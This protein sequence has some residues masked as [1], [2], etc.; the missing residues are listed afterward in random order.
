VADRK[1]FYDDPSLAQVD[2]EVIDAGETDGKPWVRLAETIFY[3][4]GGGQPADRGTIAGIAVLDVRARGT[5]VL[6]FVERPVPRGPAT[7]ILDAARRFDFRQQHTA[8]HALTALLA[9]RHDRPTTAF[10]LGDAYAAIEVAG[11][12]PSPDTLRRWE[13]ELNAELRRDPAVRTEWVE[14][15]DLERRRVRSRGLPDGH[16]GPVRL[17]EIEG[18]DVNTC[19]GTHVARLG[20]VQ[21]VHLLD[22]EAARGG[23]RIRFLAGGRVLRRLHQAATLDEA[24]QLRIGTAPEEF[25]QVLDG[26][27]AERKRLEKALRELETELAARVGA[28]LAAEPGPRF[29]R[30]L[31]GRGPEFLRAVANAV[32]ALRPEALVAL[33]GQSGEPP[34]ACFL[35]QSGPQGPADASVDGRRLQERLGAKGGGKGRVFQ[36][37]GGKWKA[38]EPILE[39]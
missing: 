30:F 35:V 11:Q 23:A 27:Q 28:E 8:Q 22:A 25:P 14:P 9:D 29:W 4:E 7:A 1:L 32:V 36:G 33:V 12:A 34:Q 16:V 18:L 19:G 15:A 13:D 39:G 20:E 6:H 3:P 31:D 38:G 24:L 17:V 37:R 26:W 5:E 2:T 21:M 10:H